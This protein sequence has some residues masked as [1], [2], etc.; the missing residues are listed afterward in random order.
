MD[1]SDWSAVVVSFRVC[2]ASLALIALP[3]ILMGW[4]LARRE[5]LGKTMLEALVQVPLVLPPVVTGYLLLLALGRN[6]FAGNWLEQN[7]GLQIAF[8]TLGAIV[9]AAVVS[10]PLLVRPARMAFELVDTQL[11]VA[12]TTLGASP[13]RVFLTVTLPLALPGLL[14]GLTLAFA[15]GLG[16]FGAT[17]TLAGNIEGQT[18][19]IPLAVYS[20]L[21][22]PGGETAALRLSLL[23]VVLSLAALILSEVWMARARHRLGLRR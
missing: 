23:A 15:R 21:Q 20:K 17:I 19:T 18:R 4:L 14:T 1:T 5:F 10:F 6:G 11:E 7:L 2:T 8:D 16:E 9:A 22:V 13:I 3:G 12:A